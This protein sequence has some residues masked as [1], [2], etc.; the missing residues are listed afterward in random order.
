MNAEGNKISELV[1]IAGGIEPPTILGDQDNGYLIGN[2]K[3]YRLPELGGSGRNW[4][5][6][7]GCLLLLV[8][9]VIMGFIHRLR[10]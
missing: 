7:L 2:I 3:T 10:K 5:Y 1:A 6:V 8:S 4:F 9:I